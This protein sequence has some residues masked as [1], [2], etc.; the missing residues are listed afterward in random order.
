VLVVRVVQVK[1]AWGQRFVAVDGGMNA[2]LRP[3]L[4]GA[5]HRIWPV[6]RRELNEPATVVGP[7]CESA[8]VLAREVSLPLDLA[9]G[10]LLAVLDAGAYGAVMA[11][12]YNAHPLPGEVVVR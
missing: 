6:Q 5:R 2:F 11:N 8:D 12:G 1:R 7:N 3:V 9:P 4:Y 10:D